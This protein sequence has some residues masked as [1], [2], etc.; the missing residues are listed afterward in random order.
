MSRVCRFIPRDVTPSF[1]VLATFSVAE[2][3]RS[4]E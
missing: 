2:R 4:D 1:T 3:E